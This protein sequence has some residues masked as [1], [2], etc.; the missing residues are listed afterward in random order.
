MTTRREPGSVTGYLPND[1]PPPGQIVLLGLQHVLTMFPATVLVAL[2]VG[3]DVGTVLTV[4]GVATVTA[5]VLSRLIGGRFIPLYYGSSFSYIAAILAVTGADFAT[6]AGETVRIAQVGIVAT[7]VINVAVGFLIRWIG[8]D[9]LDKILPPVITGSVAAVIGIAL[10][11]AALDMAAAHWGVAFITL[12]VTILFSVYLQNKGFIGL[13]PVL[14]GAVT[15]YLVSI[16]FGLIDMAPVADAAW[17]RIPRFT[18]P[19]FTDPRAWSAI[20]TI[21][22]IAVAT[23][24]ESTAHLYQIS[25][26]VDELAVRIG[27]ERYRLSNL[28]GL[29]LILDGIGD[30]INGMFGG[31]A[32]T[33]YGENNSLMVITRNYSGPALI[34][35]GILAI[36]L[37]FVGKLA[38]L[39]NTIPVAVTGGLAIYLFGVIGMQGV[40]LMMAEKV[41]LYDPRQLAVGASILIIGIG[42]HIGFGGN[43]PIEFLPSIFP[44]GLPAIA[45]A[46]V[47]GILINAIFLIFR[48][49]EVP[50]V[51]E[52]S[53]FHVEP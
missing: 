41:N 9:N 50:V 14:L 43:L 45:T 18:L 44:D 7:G 52:S 15:G 51:T 47:V 46:A 28:I 3:F 21:A 19:A 36:L 37:G 20:A 11:A 25:L 24:P 5:L 30:L 26:Y 40:A 29:N 48:P 4:S 17:F 53:E 39:V 27:R 32:G 1:V 49:P 12:L 13:L 6:Y 22:V 34:A 38:G 33:N 35:A 23:I 2:L 31:V 8:K 10:S 16:P 42:G